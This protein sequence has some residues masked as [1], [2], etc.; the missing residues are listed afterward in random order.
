MQPLIML[1]MNE[2]VFDYV[3]Y[4]IDKGYLKNFSEFIDK[5]GIC[6]TTSVNEYQNM[7]PWI[8]WVSARTGQTFSDHGVFRLGDVVGGDISQHWEVLEEHGY[9]VAAISPIN[10]VNKTKN[11][12]FWVPDPWVK[13]DAS[14]D[15]FLKSIS[16]A[17]AQAVNSN[18][19]E[20]ISK[21]A[22][23]TLLKTLLFKSKLSSWGAYLSYLFGV[24]KSQHWSKALILDRLLADVFFS[25]WAKHRPDFSTLFL[26]AAAHIQH[27]YMFNSRAYS[28][29]QKNPS[30]YIRSNAD[31]VLEIYELYDSIL[32]EA[33]KIGA[34]VMVGTGLTQVPYYKTT[35]YYRLKDHAGFLDGLGLKY[36]TVQP[37]M[38]RDF[39]VTFDCVDS[40]SAASGVICGLCSRESVR[41]FDVDN[42]G[43]SIFVTLSYSD[44]IP[45][46]FPL[47]DLS[48][49]LIDGGFG[50]KVSFV[51]IKN[52]HHDPR[53]YFLD[54]GTCLGVKPDAIRIEDLYQK[55]L[56]HF[57]SVREASQEKAS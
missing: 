4:Y 3:H 1:E 40:A 36:K 35:Y 2:I 52:G 10:G 8:Q 5:Y 30:W 41:V 31:P 16:S 45:S 34:R 13:T 32:G 29:E 18:A 54:S 12:P 7:E 46:E 42:R 27:H 49:N 56:D 14:G 19:S 6:R 26:N 33:S 37:R 51:A 25:E 53:G 9:S 22:L 11:S 17:V 23:V 47:Y 43:D 48:G 38:S 39:L 28:G 55:V 20:N 57:P 24:L 15:E 21:E 50:G 44:E